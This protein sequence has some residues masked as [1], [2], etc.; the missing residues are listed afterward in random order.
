[1][2]K[3]PIFINKKITVIY[4]GIEK[5]VY[6]DLPKLSSGSHDGK[7]IRH[8]VSIGELNNNKA[9]DTVLKILPQVKGVHY[10]I[11]GEGKNRNKLENLIKSNDLSDRVTL[12]GHKPNAKSLL[13]Q[14]DAFLLPSRTEALGYVV[15][16][17][18]QAGLP[19]IA[20]RVG[21]VP[22]ILRD[23]PYA[24]LYNH[25]TD[26]IGLLDEPL[27]TGFKWSDSRFDFDKM[28]E[29]T[30]YIYKSNV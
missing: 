20:R 30:I 18:L 17:A 27:Q 13:S 2:L 4:N 24:K 11:I 3:I 23:L 15:L 25:D 28:V 21:G 6:N 14:Y 26:L 16:E 7:T 22:E 12:Y 19:V 1:L 8:I 10:H 9:H 5:K 29:R